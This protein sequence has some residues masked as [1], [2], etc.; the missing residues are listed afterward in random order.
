MGMKARIDKLEKR[1]PSNEPTGSA[2]FLE[3]LDESGNKKLF[4]ASKGHPPA[5]EDDRRSAKQQGR[6]VVTVHFSSGSVL[7]PPRSRP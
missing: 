6:Q 5:S 7:K 2:G 3:F 4:H 1:M